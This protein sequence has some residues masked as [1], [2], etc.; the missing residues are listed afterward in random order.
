[1]PV[2]SNQ[3]RL[4]VGKVIITY[5]L[6]RESIPT[7]INH[8]LTNQVA[9]FV[10]DARQN[11]FPRFARIL[12]KSHL[13]PVW[14]RTRF[15]NYKVSQSSIPTPFPTPPLHQQH[16]RPQQ[17]YRPNPQIRRP[18]RLKNTLNKRQLT[19]QIPRLKQRLFPQ[20]ENLRCYAA[21]CPHV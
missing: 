20:P 10:L 4:Q 9:L 2:N 15:L 11:L 21:G 1:M 3:H 12:G 6:C 17:T 19:P 16:K 14:E 7:L 8:Q 13:A 18:K 5:L